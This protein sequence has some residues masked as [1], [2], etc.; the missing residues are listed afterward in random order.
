MC[1]ILIKIK[2]IK[3]KYMLHGYTVSD[4]HCITFIAL[5][6]ALRVDL[7]MLMDGYTMLQWSKIFSVSYTV[8]KM[9]KTTRHIIAVE[10]DD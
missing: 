5:Y 8:S 6:L 7:V 2:G 10:E 1:N 3:F 9:F 4:V